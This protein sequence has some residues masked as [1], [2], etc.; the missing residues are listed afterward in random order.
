[1]GLTD[2]AY[3]QRL[4]S[5]IWAEW[6]DPSEVRTDVPKT[7]YALVYT[8]RDAAGYKVVYYASEDLTWGTKTV[9]GGALIPTS[10]LEAANLWILLGITALAVTAVMMRRHR[11]LT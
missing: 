6:S 5:L 1:M 3:N 9:V 8:G 11:A 4:P 10:I 2:L 7:G